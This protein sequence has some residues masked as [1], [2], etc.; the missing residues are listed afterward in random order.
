MGFLISQHAGPNFSKRFKEAKSGTPFTTY[1][2]HKKIK[3]FGWIVRSYSDI[4]E[5]DEPRVEWLRAFL[6]N[7]II[8][9]S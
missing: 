8:T 3:V 2:P 1:H 7:Y 6:T 4:R 5:S 9:E